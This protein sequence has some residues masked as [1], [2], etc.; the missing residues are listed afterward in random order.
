[1]HPA[2]KP[3]ALIPTATRSL[4]LAVAAKGARIFDESGRD[5]IDASSGPLA[6]SLGHGHPKVLA[7]L[8][9]Q[10]G[11]VDYVHRTQFRN[12]AAEHLADLVTTR[13]GGGL[14]HVLFVGS[15]SEANEV[16]MK[17][18]HMYWAAANPTSTGSRRVRSAI[19]AT[20]PAPWGHP[21]SPGTPPPTAR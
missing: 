6:V 20:P 8:R 10:F 14:D 4:P 16:A 1:M 18:A 11:A 13:L 21:A 2:A 15:G 17:A 12:E 7:A 19:T 3:P 9:R 5:Y